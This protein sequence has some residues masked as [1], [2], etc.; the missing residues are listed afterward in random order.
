MKSETNLIKK[1]NVIRRTASFYTA[2]KRIKSNKKPRQAISRKPLKNQCVNNV[3]NNSKTSVKSESGLKLFPK[4]GASHGKTSSLEYA[5]NS[6][7]SSV[8]DYKYL[9]KKQLAINK[10]NKSTLHSEEIAIVKHG[11]KRLKIMSTKSSKL[12]AEIGEPSNT[13]ACEVTKPSTKSLF[14]CNNSSI[15]GTFSKHKKHN[16]MLEQEKSKSSKLKEMNN[17]TVKA[18]NLI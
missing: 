2:P 6:I 17:T 12:R 3:E 16:N 11:A 15:R 7:G 10:F 1:S 14:L 9:N 5:N 18:E 8:R 13:T 4:S